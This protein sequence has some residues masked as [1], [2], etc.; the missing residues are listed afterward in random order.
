[1]WSVPSRLR[2][3]MVFIMAPD[4]VRVAVTRLPAVTWTTSSLEACDVA[5]VV[6]LPMDDGVLVSL[7]SYDM[8][9]DAAPLL[10]PPVVVDGV[11]ISDV[12]SRWTKFSRWRNEL[13]DPLFSPS[14]LC[15]FS[16]FHFELNSINSK[17]ISFVP[18]EVGIVGG[19][20]GVLDVIPV[21][22]AGDGVAPLLCRLFLAPLAA[23]DDPLRSAAASG[24]S[25]T[26]RRRIDVLEML[27]RA[28]ELGHALE[29]RARHVQPDH[30]SRKNLR[31]SRFSFLFRRR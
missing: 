6:V 13:L 19:P 18:A 28:T 2:R 27:Q 16:H 14:F 7:S 30:L 15:Q 29:T 8:S 17:F 10:P 22:V 11:V 24:R 26:D 25:P 20:E 4:R 23:P 1:M 31:R 9:D 3:E 21:A 12:R 5:S